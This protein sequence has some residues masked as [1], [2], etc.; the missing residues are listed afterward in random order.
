LLSEP[1]QHPDVILIAKESAIIYFA[2]EFNV[3]VQGASS[4]ALALIL[5]PK[6]HILVMGN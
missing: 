4:H 1:Y 5:F 2:F 6:L 3:L